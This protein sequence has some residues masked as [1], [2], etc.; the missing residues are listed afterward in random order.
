MIVWAPLTAKPCVATAGTL[1][2]PVCP[3]VGNPVRR[4]GE[5]GDAC[6][7]AEVGRALLCVA[8]RGAGCEI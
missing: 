7:A 3:T 1:S 4:E 8:W 2:F 5:I 6:P